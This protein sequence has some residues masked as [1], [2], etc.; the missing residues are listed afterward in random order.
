MGKTENDHNKKSD[1]NMTAPAQMKWIDTSKKRNK[2]GW[3]N[4]IV[5]PKNYIANEMNET[6]DE[7]NKYPTDLLN[8]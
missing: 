7:P 3:R 6:V 1:D 5:I 8:E 4:D 2:N